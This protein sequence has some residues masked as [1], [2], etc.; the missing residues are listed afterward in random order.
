[1]LVV[2]LAVARNYYLSILD[3]G[4]GLFPHLFSDLHLAWVSRLHRLP[5]SRR[6][7]AIE[8]KN[9]YLEYYSS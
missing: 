1:M 4:H 6:L 7:M 9:I 3:F 2:A 5:R 8:I